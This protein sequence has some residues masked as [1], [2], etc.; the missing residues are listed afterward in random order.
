MRPSMRRCLSGA[1]EIQMKSI[2]LFRTLISSRSPLHHHNR[3]LVDRTLMQTDTQ[4]NRIVGF[5]ACYGD[6]ARKS[7]LET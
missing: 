6:E 3:A 5:Y 1:D 2:S 7:A 4:A